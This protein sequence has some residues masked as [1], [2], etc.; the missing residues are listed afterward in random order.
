MSVSIGYLKELI[1]EL[2]AR[3]GDGGWGADLDEHIKHINNPYYPDPDLYT[4]LVR[5]SCN[6]MIDDGCQNMVLM[7]DLGLTWEPARVWRTE[8]YGTISGGNVKSD[9]DAMIQAARDYWNESKERR[10]SWS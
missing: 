2:E 3:E 6:D 1:E 4:Y 8:C 9:V 7:N 5:Y 10:S